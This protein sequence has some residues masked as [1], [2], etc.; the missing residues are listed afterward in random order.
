MNVID[1]FKNKVVEKFYNHGLFVA[2]NSLYVILIVFGLFILSL[3]QITHVPP[4]GSSLEVFTESSRT[5]R[6]VQARL[7]L[8]HNEIHD[9]QPD[10]P[11][12]YTG[13]PIAYV[14]HI[15]VRCGLASSLSSVTLKPT[16]FFRSCILKSNEIR[17][18]LSSIQYDNNQLENYCL[19][20]TESSNVYLKQ[21]LPNYGCLLLSPLN[22]WNNDITK[23]Y[24][25]SSPLDTIQQIL[26]SSS[27]DQQQSFGSRRRRRRLF[28]DITFGVPYRLIQNEFGRQEYQMTYAITLLLMNASSNY[29]QILKERLESKYYL[30]ANNNNTI[31]DDTDIFHVHFSRKS[32]VYYL[33]LVLLYLVVFLYIYYSVSQFECVKSKWGL[34]LA[35]VMQIFCSLIISLALSSYFN[36]TPRLNGGEVFPYLVVFIGLENLVVITRSVTSQTIN[37]DIRH[38]VGNG[39]KKESW[40]IFKH[41]LYELLIVLIGYV[42]FVPTVQEFCQ[43]AFIG[44]SIDFFMQMNFFVAVLSIDIRR[45][46][47]TSATTSSKMIK[48][49]STIQMPLQ[50]PSSLSSTIISSTSRKHNQSTWAK[51]RFI[52]RT[53]MFLILIWFLLIFYKSCLIVDLLHKNVKINREEIEGFVSEKTL[54]E[55]Y[56]KQRST[57]NISRPTNKEN[58]K[59]LFYKKFQWHLLLNFDHWPTLFSYYNITNHNRYLTIL[60]SIY[61][62]IPIQDQTSEL[63]NDNSLL[64]EP[65]NIQQTVKNDEFKSNSLHVSFS[66]AVLELMFIVF[67]GFL[68]LSGLYCLFS[69]SRGHSQPYAASANAV[70][71]DYDVIPIVM[72]SKKTSTSIIETISSNEIHLTVC[73]SDYS[74]LLW[75]YSTGDLITTIQREK[76]SYHV[77]CSVLVD[78]LLILGCSNGQLEIWNIFHQQHLKTEHCADGGITH[79]IRSHNSMYTV[80]VT[81]Q[82]GHILLYDI[83]MTMNKQINIHCFYQQRVHQW[84]IRTCKIEASRIM[85]GSD[86]HSIKITQLIN[87]QCL[88]T[89]NKHKAPVSCLAT[90]KNN[91]SSLVSGCLDGQLC[92]WDLTTGRCLLTK[93]HAHNGFILELMSHDTVLASLGNDD[94]IC[95]W[96]RRTL[97]YLYD[98]RL[99]N[100]TLCFTLAQNYLLHTHSGYLFV[101]DTKTNQ[102]KQTL[103][104]QLNNSTASHAIE[105]IYSLTKQTIIIH[106][107]NDILYSL[108]LPEKFVND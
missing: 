17:D 60:P 40:T 85:T 87:G 73:Y 35:A 66:S 4:P 32:F 37:D 24:D 51:Y 65:N 70:Q 3:F 39:L 28:N 46:P 19:H 1:R 69:F 7:E 31:Q 56:M 52:Q 75:N 5:F 101:T 91:P 50:Q 15:V 11:L 63:Q 100:S 14:Q 93:Q 67:F 21:Y 12:W 61:L 90:D 42:T 71:R 82:T 102:L 16:D 106:D 38:R 81:T 23:L 36:I 88:F 59:L 48:Q 53:I 104:Y 68:F 44:I 96:K 62:S 6:P 8:N 84:P 89:F 18:L 98:I 103:L 97:D 41:L 9:K 22:I 10:K 105:M 29:L 94:R 30:S 64:N 72:Y 92:L 27:S 45:I 57:V 49:S 43:F 78:E 25:D 2:D 108:S 20:V 47:T 54:T 95:I 79:L 86:D 26:T 55:H 77:W 76:P 34:A 107:N 58:D 99:N 13:Y 83:Q 80:L 74:I 33:P